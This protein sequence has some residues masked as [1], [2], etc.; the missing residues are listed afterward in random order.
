VALDRPLPLKIEPGPRGLKVSLTSLDTFL[1][2]DADPFIDNPGIRAGL[3]IHLQG[4]HR[5]NFEARGVCAL[6]AY[7]GLVVSLQIL[8]FDGNPGE[9]RGVSAT[10]VK[11]S[12]DH[13]AGTASGAESLICE[14]NRLG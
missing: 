4:S 14:N 8:F 1:A 12:T 13:F 6:M 5:A 11:V 3:P 7:L 9:R 2:A 10:A